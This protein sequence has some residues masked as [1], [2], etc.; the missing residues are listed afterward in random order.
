LAPLSKLKQFDLSSPEVKQLMQQR[1]GQNI[2]LNE[3][4]IAPQAIFASTALIEVDRK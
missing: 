2:P 3:T 4:V 1:Y